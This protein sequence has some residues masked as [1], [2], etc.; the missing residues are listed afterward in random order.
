VSTDPLKRTSLG[1]Y[2]SA[3]RGCCALKFLHA[4]QIGQALLGHTGTGRGVAPKKFNRENLK[5]GL[6]FR[7]LGLI[8][9][10]KHTQHTQILLNNA[11]YKTTKN[12]KPDTTQ[13]RTGQ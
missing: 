7:V 5:F 4:L 11:E 8:T 3:L 6:K 12:I 2:I 10:H 13:S 9:T 1:Y